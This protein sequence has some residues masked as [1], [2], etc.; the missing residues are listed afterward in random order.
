MVLSITRELSW[1]LE[2]TDSCCPQ[3]LRPLYQRVGGRGPQQAESFLP[4]GRQRTGG[5]SAWEPGD[6]RQEGGQWGQ[7]RAGDRKKSGQGGE[8]EAA[9]TAGYWPAGI[10]F[11]LNLIVW[12]GKVVFYQISSFY[13][14]HSQMIQSYINLLIQIKNCRDILSQFD[15]T[16]IQT[17]R[18][19]NCQKV[20]IILNGNFR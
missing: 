6:P 17:S 18:N 20:D 1:K 9:T 5:A 4:G 15:N 11:T 3:V 12:V 14:Y 13:L 16:N 10:I 2:L 19:Y 8:A 7:S